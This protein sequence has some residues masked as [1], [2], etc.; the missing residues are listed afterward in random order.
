LLFATR[1]TLNPMSVGLGCLVVAISTELSVLL[2]ERYHQER[3]AGRDPAEALRTT[4]KRTGAAVAASAVTAIAGFAVL[5]VS[6]VRML[7]EFG[8]TTLVDL[9]VSLVG[10]VLV[11]P[12]VLE[13]TERV[14]FGRGNQSLPRHARGTNEPGSHGPRSDEAGS[15]G[16]WFRPAG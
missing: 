14:G 7:Q 5:A 16:G 4:Y 15:G 1:I 6:Q 12:S 11:L 13:L 9:G 8:L 2:A 3:V 10:V